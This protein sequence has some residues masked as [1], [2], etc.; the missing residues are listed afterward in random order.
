MKYY[1]I[2]YYK[3][4]NWIDKKYVSSELGA[5]DAIRKTGLKNSIVEVTEITKEQFDKYRGI[6]KERADARKAVDR[7]II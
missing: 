6:I 7:F 1:E 5:T 2:A 4:R 3:H